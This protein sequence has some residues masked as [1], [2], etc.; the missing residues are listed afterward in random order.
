MTISH[1]VETEGVK[2]QVETSPIAADSFDTSEDS[3]SQELEKDSIAVKRPRSEVKSPA[4][5]ADN[6]AEALPLNRE[7]SFCMIGI[8]DNPVDMSTRVVSWVKVQRHL[9]LIYNLRL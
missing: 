8:E 7:I 2:S 9:D 4:R 3:I 5:D 1:P 6:L